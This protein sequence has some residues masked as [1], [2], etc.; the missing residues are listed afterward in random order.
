MSGMDGIDTLRA[1]AADPGLNTTRVVVVTTFEVDEYVFAALQAGASGF[2]LKDSAPEELTHAIRV[3][4][5]GEALLSPS[6]T[7]KVIG[8]FG[9]HDIA[10]VEGLDTL[11]PR[12]REMVAW[13]ATGRSAASGRVVM[14][15]GLAVVVSS[16]TL[17][18]ATDVI[19]SAITLCVSLL[20]WSRL[21]YRVG[22]P[23]A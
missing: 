9:R 18:L 8:L 4:A 5:S 6:I 23:P 1:I 11:T 10:P 13:V 19:F 2:V 22:G 12:E 7:R 20:A 3:V 14:H 15:S 16:A 17:Y 21:R